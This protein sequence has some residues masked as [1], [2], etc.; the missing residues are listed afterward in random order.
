MEDQI[1]NQLENFSEIPNSVMKE[2]ILEPENISEI[3]DELPGL[4]MDSE[5]G[6]TETVL[7]DSVDKM[8]NLGFIPEKNITA[9]IDSVLPALVVLIFS[10]FKMRVDKKALKLEAKEKSTI[11]QLVKDS[12]AYSDVKYKN[13][14][15]ALILTV[16]TI[17]ASKAIVV[18]A[19]KMDNKPVNDE[20]ETLKEVKE[21]I[22]MEKVRKPGS[23]RKAGS[24]N[25]E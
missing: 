14:I 4:E 16:L 22:E 7:T 2:V 19:E 6:N 24:K 9:L 17:Y 18:I 8:L 11:D 10:F 23:G 5:L 20:P 1:L 12:L 25:K 21:K 3:V 13:P 15:T